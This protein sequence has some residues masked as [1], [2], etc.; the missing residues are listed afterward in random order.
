MWPFF[1]ITTF[2]CWLLCLALLIKHLKS[3][4][5]LIKIL[6]KP[7]LWSLIILALSAVIV[8]SPWIMKI[9]S[10]QLDPMSYGILMV[11]FMLLLL[12]LG[13]PV[14]FTMAI[15]GILGTWYLTDFNICRA[16]II[17]SVYDSVANYFFACFLF[18]FLWEFCALRRV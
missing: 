4:L 1:V 2:G 12:F 10:I 7:W 5:K 9:F 6:T 14:T 11:G 13:M 18:L 3:H 16:L 17:L 15:I 8:I